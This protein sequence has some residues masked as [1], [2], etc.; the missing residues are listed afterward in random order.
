[1]TTE[2]HEPD[3]GALTGH[4]PPVIHSHLAYFFVPLPEPLG[5]PDK[6]VVRCH[7]L[8][9]VDW[10][11]HENHTHETGPPPTKHMAASLLFHR[12]SGP[13]ADAVIRNDVFDLADSVMGSNDLPQQE[14]DQATEPDQGHTAGT[15]R[16]Q[17]ELLRDGTVV[18]MAVA[19][20]FDNEDE[21]WQD[22]SDAFDR[23][24]AY[25]RD[26]QRSYF[27][28]RRRPVRLVTRETLPF[29]VPFALR[30]LSD[31]DRPGVPFR[32]PLSMYLLNQNL[33]REIRDRDLDES[34][35]TALTSAL[36][37]QGT[38]G[39]FTGYLDFVR[40]AQVALDIEGAYRAAVLFIATACEV[41]LD[42]LLAHMLWEEK[43]RPENA[44]TVFDSWLTA[45]VKARY[46]DRLGGKWA[47]DQSGPVTEWSRTVAGLRNRV[48]H[49]GYEPSLAEARAARDAAIALESH[50]ADLLAARVSVYPR[51]ALALLG[52]PGLRRRNLWTGA[53]D[54]L[55]NDPDQVPW[56]ETF[57]RW[58]DALERARSDSPVYTA[59]ATT[60]AWVVAVVHPGGAV[61]WVVHD[62]SAAM[63]ATVEADGVQNVSPV[64]YG[65]LGHTVRAMREGGHAAAVSVAFPHATIFDNQV[66]AWLP[67]YRLLPLAGVMV[68]GRN[69]DPF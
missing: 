17:P 27:L 12:T 8:T 13:S 49:G 6:H 28:A 34:E 66:H 67:E 25:I 18:E 52:D 54:R 43:T 69:L 10:W 47:L 19:F 57:A 60:Q 33:V 11:R 20:D 21:S 23:G 53:L 55:V 32:A 42:A 26:I 41:L 3:D 38:G 58:R 35:S 65:T 37:L 50:I 22:I 4:E 16:G 48:I 44:A 61:R 56:Q 5:L 40:E 39:V 7:A 1:M 9:G 45:R 14:G 2:R 62:R 64:Q 51:T 15:S 68:D 36:Y 30:R 59:P 29:A 46:H 31:D 63:A 24:L